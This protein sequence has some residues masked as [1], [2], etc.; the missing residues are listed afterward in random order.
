MGNYLGE[1]T[2]EIDPKD[3]NYIIEFVSAGPKNYAFLLDTGKTKSTIKGITQN[4]VTSLIIKYESIKNI[5]C[6]DRSAKISVKHLRFI[7]DNK[8]WNVST[9][10]IYKTYGFVYDKRVLKTDLSTKPY[11]F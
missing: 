3:G 11:G 9:Q 10:D 2:N 5:V 8:K 1:F 7:R 6:N 4:N